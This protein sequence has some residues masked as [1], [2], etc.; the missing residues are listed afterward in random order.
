MVVR[1][2]LSLRGGRKSTKTSKKSKKYKK[3]KKYKKSK[4]VKSRNK[5]KGINK[6]SIRRNNRAGL[7]ELK[8]NIR[9]TN[10]GVKTIDTPYGRKWVVNGLDI[11]RNDVFRNHVEQMQVI[12]E[13]D[14]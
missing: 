9:P 1:R 11:K 14:E 4:R 5:G 13:N 2:T 6:R 12:D 8:C 3:Y 7:G 10:I